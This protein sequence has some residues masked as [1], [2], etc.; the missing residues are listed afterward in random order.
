MSPSQDTRHRL[1]KAARRLFAERGFDGAS[2]RA[3]TGAAGTNVAAVGYHFGSKEELYKEVIR[4]LDAPLAEW[5]VAL[6]HDEETPVR[7][8]IRLLLHEVFQHLWDNPDQTRFMVELRLYR[9]EWLLDLAEIL[10]PITEA[11]IRLVRQG[12]AQGVIREGEPLLLAMSLM[13]Q[14]VY[15]M[16]VTR[17]IPEGIL[18]VEPCTDQGRAVYLDHMVD[19]ALA[20]LAPVPPGVRGEGADPQERRAS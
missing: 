13:A 6:S 5:I 16:L 9:T 12:Q 17:K 19:F 8:R 14:P 4:A 20:G 10:A 3:I 7:Q 2:V 1:L 11:L 15:F 18:P